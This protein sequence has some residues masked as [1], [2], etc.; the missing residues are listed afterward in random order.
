MVSEQSNNETLENNLGETQIEIEPVTT[1]TATIEKLLQNLKK[2][3]IYPTGVVSQSYA[4]LSDQKMPHTPLLSD[5]WAHTSSHFHLTAIPFYAS[6]DVQPSNP[7]GH[8]HPHVPPMN[9]G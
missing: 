7:S 6:S 3:S 5:A 4:P 9:F 8:P 1:A 2:S